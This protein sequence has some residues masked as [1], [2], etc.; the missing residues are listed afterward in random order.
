M[1]ARFFCHIIFFVISDFLWYEK[2]FD[3]IK[4]RKKKRCWFVIFKVSFAK[5]TTLFQVYSV[6]D[7]HGK[8]LLGQEGE[9]VTEIEM[10]KGLGIKY[11]F[12]GI[13]LRLPLST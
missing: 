5:L 7:H 13:P 12:E 10:E 9:K 4:K 11:Y 2:I 8:A 1:S 3:K 6:E